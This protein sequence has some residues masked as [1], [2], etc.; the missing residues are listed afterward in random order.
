M[1]P[2]K[3]LVIKLFEEKNRKRRAMLY[4]LFEGHF[5]LNVTALFLAEMISSELE[6]DS[7][8]ISAD[9][10]YFIRQYYHNKPTQI[11]SGNT[12]IIPSKKIENI[13][14]EVEKSVES[15]ELV[16]TDIDALPQKNKFRQIK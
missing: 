9:D 5:S 7:E 1:K 4:Q 10:I 16:W 2:T 3:E 11:K 13:I 12:T 8:L 6:A 15:D 14:P